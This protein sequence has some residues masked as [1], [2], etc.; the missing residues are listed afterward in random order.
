MVGKATAQDST[1]EGAPRENLR[2]IQ[3]RHRETP[4]SETPDAILMIQRIEQIVGQGARLTL[5]VKRIDTQRPPEGNELEWSAA[6]SPSSST[7]RERVR[8]T[9][10]ECRGPADIQMILNGLRG[11]RI[12]TYLMAEIVTWAR[13]WPLA[14]VMKIELSWQDEKPGAHDGNNK[15]RRD[16]FYEQFGIEFIPSETESQITARSKYMLAENLTTDDAERAWRLNIQK[17]NASDWLV[18]QQRKLE[19]QEGQIAKLK[20]KA[21]SLQT[22]KDRIEAHPY[23]NAV[24]RFLTNPLA[25]GCLALVAVAFSL[26]KEVVS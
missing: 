25:L 24:C 16:R 20:R 13:Q 6:Y 26:A 12:G 21:A 11:F 8:L 4:N 19:E 10:G 18:D 1:T 9:H 7:D 17:V 23:R 15:V 3:V 14:E 5:R 2:V 22:T